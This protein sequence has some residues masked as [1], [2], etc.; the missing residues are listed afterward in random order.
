MK[1]LNYSQKRVRRS[2]VYS[3]SLGGMVIA[4]LISSPFLPTA[5]PISMKSVY[6][7][8]AL[9]FCY[10]DFFQ[11]NFPCQLC[12]SKLCH[13]WTNNCC[14]GQGHNLG[15]L[16]AGSASSK[17]SCSVMCGDIWITHNTISSTSF[18]FKCIQ[19]NFKKVPQI[20]GW[21]LTFCE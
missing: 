4:A 15:R 16:D 1:I 11:T 8:Q 6:N 20:S 21:L 10:S 9:L 12:P 3:F 14:F 7:R 19:S 13:F 2:S 17:W 5:G 18:L